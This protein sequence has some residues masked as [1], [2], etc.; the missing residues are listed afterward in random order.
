MPFFSIILPTYNRAS[1]LSRSIGSVLRQDFQD[2]ELLI[3]DDGSTDHTKEIVNSF[4]DQR[5]KYIYQEN[6]ERSAARNN[7]IKLATGEWICFLDSDDEYSSL[8][9]LKLSMFIEKSNALPSIIVT[10]LLQNNGIVAKQKRFLNL[11]E[12]ILSEISVKF[13]IPTQ[14]CVHHSILEMENF[15]VRF[16]IW[17]DTHLWLRIAAQ[18]PVYQIEEYTVTQ[19]VHNE[20]TVVQGMNNVRVVE[21]NQY[22]SAILD[23][24][25]NHASRFEGKLSPLFFDQYIDSKYRMYLYRARQNKQFR[26]ASQLWIKAWQ[27]RPSVYLFTEYPKIVLNYLNIGLHAR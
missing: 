9:M 1:F 11:N 15:D 3:I 7:G 14:V 19:H 24:K 10:G 12:E 2:W 5:I 4:N 6:S 20:G 25:I 21:V 16:R 18:Y 27:H 23:L 8:H 26:V 17:E 22:V 13:L